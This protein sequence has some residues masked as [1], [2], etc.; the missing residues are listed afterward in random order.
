MKL[1]Q[2]LARLIGAAKRCE[3][4]DNLEWARKHSEKI[5]A[6]VK[7]LMPS[8]SGFDDGTQIIPSEC[9]EDKLVFNTA[10]HHMDEQ[11]GYDG[12]TQHTV[13][14]RPSLAFDFRVVVMGRDRN[15][16]KDYISECFNTALDQEVPEAAP[17]VRKFPVVYL[18]ETF[19]EVETMDSIHV[20]LRVKGTEQWGIALHV[21]QLD[22]EAVVQLQRAGVMN[23][24]KYMVND[25]QSKEAA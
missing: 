16:I 22:A 19:H 25:A 6:L 14:V 20:R 21:Q 12:W 24:R 7:S 11:G 17:V 3:E 5:A 4:T 15:E 13:I 18:K 8:G 23:E 1:Y 9:T 10:F 2:K